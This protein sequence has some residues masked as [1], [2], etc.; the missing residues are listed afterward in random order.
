M[1][2]DHLTFHGLEELEHDIVLVTTEVAY[3]SLIDRSGEKE[4]QLARTD[5]NAESLLPYLPRGSDTPRQKSEQRPERASGS[6]RRLAS[7]NYNGNE[8]DDPLDDDI[9]LGE[10][11][12]EADAPE[13]DDD[14]SDDED[15]ISS[16]LQSA[17][18][19]SSGQGEPS[20]QTLLVAACRWIRAMVRRNMITERSGRFRVRVY[21]AKG[22]KVLLTG[23]FTVQNTQPEEEPAPPPKRPEMPR[24]GPIPSIPTVL[25]PTSSQPPTQLALPQGPGSHGGP[26]PATPPI[27]S[28]TPSPHH[29]T[30]M[31]GAAT[32][33]R[34]LGDCYTQFGDLVLGSVSSLQNV[35]SLTNRDLGTQLRESR[36][37][38]DTLV[39]SVLDFRVQELNHSSN[40]Q[41][42]A[43]QDHRTALA[44][45]AIQQLGET[46][47]AFF[48]ARG[49]PPN[50]AEV[51]QA[52][53][54]SPELVSALDDPAVRE[55]LRDPRNLQGLAGLLKQVGQQ[56]Q[57]QRAGGTTP[58]QAATHSA[59]QGH[60]VLHGYPVSQGYPVPPQ[61]PQG[62]APQS[63]PV[64]AN[65]P[66]GATAPPGVSPNAPQS[67]A[68]Q[69]PPPTPQPMAGYG[70]PPAHPGYPAGGGQ[71]PGSGAAGV[72]PGQP[73]RPP[74]PGAH[75][76]G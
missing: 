66:M 45:D 41:Q 19:S 5:V 12:L 56:H 54:S 35:L 11:D 27:L 8:D 55:V 34:H 40:T 51:M 53:S 76:A 17:L 44:R 7:G 67:Y 62:Y 48:V 13:V 20:Q 75:P 30:A 6:S 42:V 14:A 23:S 68:H 38:V 24:P 64:Y 59:P 2:R 15:E 49:V 72:A 32:A 50:L 28:P 18:E 26:L 22:S 47:K 61:A 33:Y 58:P 37:Q 74:N 63:M 39:G 25:G 31:T 36:G 16:V 71:A 60:P 65:R 1:Y 73:S 69:Q 57:A 29:D 9:D 46:A 4:L 70:Q 21:S 10:P 3:I 43:A 52:I